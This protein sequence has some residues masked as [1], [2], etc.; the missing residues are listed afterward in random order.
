MSIFSERLK[1]S[2][3]AKQWTRKQA[4]QEFKLPY[5]TYSNYENGSREPDI[6]TITKMAKT[7]GTSTDFL[8]GKTDNPSL[9]NKNTYTKNVDLKDDPV[10]ISYGGKPVSKDDMEIIKA[11]L[12]RHED[13]E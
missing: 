10:V 6:D 4:S 5:S 9:P 8:L 1:N 3:E 13:N 11:I 2:R 12:R 7:F